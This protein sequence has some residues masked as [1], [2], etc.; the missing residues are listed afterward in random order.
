MYDVIC[1]QDEIQRDHATYIWQR[2]DWNLEEWSDPEDP[3]PE[4]YTILAGIMEGLI[5][6]LN[7][8]L[9][10]GVYRNHR[11]GLMRRIQRRSRDPESL[12]QGLSWPSRITPFPHRIVLNKTD[13]SEAQMEYRVKDYFKRRNIIALSGSLMFI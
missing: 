4:H 7:W 3:D 1:T 10:L 9:G 13:Y 5:Q 8:G 2:L 6:S 11:K 12:F